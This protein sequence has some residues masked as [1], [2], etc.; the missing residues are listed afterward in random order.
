MFNIIMIKV[1][2][3]LQVIVV[4]KS[5]VKLLGTKVEI[6]L[7]KA[8]PESWAHLKYIPHPNETGDDS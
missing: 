7:K 1:H 5:H 3:L 4:S 8:E 2:F 6:T